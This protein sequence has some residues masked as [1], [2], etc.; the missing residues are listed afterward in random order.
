VALAWAHLAA[1]DA[2]RARAEAERA[3]AMSEAMGY[4]WGQVDAEEVLE[5]LD[6]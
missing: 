2:A 5:R 6:T 1:G 3:R 4:P